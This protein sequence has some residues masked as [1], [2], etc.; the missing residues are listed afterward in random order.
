MSEAMRSFDRRAKNVQSTHR[1]LAGGYT[2][3][4]NKNGIVELKPR[5]TISLG[6]LRYIVLFALAFIG[7]K[8]LILSQIGFEAYDGHL[9]FFELG[10]TGERM[11]AWLMQIDPATAWIANLLQSLPI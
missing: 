11:G 9:A 4:I 7:L 2:E 1:K 10:S 3:K 6:P 8:G 5:K